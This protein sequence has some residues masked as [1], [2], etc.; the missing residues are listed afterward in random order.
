MMQPGLTTF[1]A[2][3][4]VASAAL[5]SA[6]AQQAGRAGFEA[7]AELFEEACAG[8]HT[9]AGESRTP[10]TMLLRGL[11]PRAIV[12][13]LEDGVMRVEGADLTREQRIGLAEY[14]TGRAYANE[15]LP[16]SAFCVDHGWQELG[17]DA[18]S[19]MGWGG[20]LEATGFQPGELAGLSADDVPDLELRWAF[21]FP[22]AGEV[23][24]RPTVIG[25]AL[26][27]GG[28]F[29]EVLALDAA[30]GC[31]RWSF[32]ADAAV[33]GAVLAGEGP[34]GRETAYFVDYR[35][36][37]YALDVASGTVVWKYK[38]GWHSTSN[39][40]GSPALHDGRLFVPVSSL[41]VAVAGDPRYE[42]CTAS[43]AVA[44]LDAM[45]G[46]VLWY[47]RVIPGY[48]EEAGTNDIGTQLWAPSGAPVWSSPTVDTA[49]GL[50]Y[51]GTGENYTR[52]T[53]ASSDAIIAIDID[54]GELA[55]SFQATPDD[56][57]TMACTSSTARENCPDPPGPDFDFGMAPMLVRRT[58]GRE[59]LVAGQKSGVVWALDPDDEGAVLWSSRVGKGGVLGGIHWGMATDGRYAYAPNADRDLVVV[60]LH[61]E[62]APAPGMYALDLI[63]GEVVWSVAAPEEACDGKRRCFPALSAAPAAIPG[64]VFAGGLDGHM[65]AY[66]AEDGRIL[67]DF[68]TTEVTETSGG[69]PGRGGAI[70]GPGPVIAGGMLFTNSGYAPFGQMPGNLLLAFGVR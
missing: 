60:D 2:T 37:A 6:C 13:S 69:V 66:A 36:N 18:I 10:G 28:P 26:L 70:D 4:L 50:V 24:T 62:L 43:G 53:T 29:G 14:L 55:W 12:A 68:D 16:E 38:A 23:R 48:P 64:V 32:E 33:R 46:D 42:C 51:A 39:T 65:R 31:V 7:G 58:D 3:G 56:A 17:L 1:A 25:D 8:C 34:G 63:T 47:H 44:A 27:V 19:S 40:T 5:I 20:N 61:P 15:T 11:S 57:F 59:I 9:A 52:P 30:R 21:A 49:R 67:W 41:E 22:D 54:T 45:T 35:T